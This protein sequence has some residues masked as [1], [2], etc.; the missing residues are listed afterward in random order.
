MTKEMKDEQGFTLGENIYCVIQDLCDYID[1]N[2]LENN[3]ELE[4]ILNELYHIQNRWNN[5]K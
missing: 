2:R 5:Q 4:F 3:S 1:N